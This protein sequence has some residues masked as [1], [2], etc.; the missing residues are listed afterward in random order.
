MPDIN[1]QCFKR[2]LSTPYIYAEFKLETAIYWH[3]GKMSC[4]SRPT[5]HWAVCINFNI[6]SPFFF[7][8]CEASP[9]VK[10]NIYG[11]KHHGTAVYK[12]FF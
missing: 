12:L 6:S 4:D 8:N 7:R 2:S 5:R 11:I 9:A 10:P 1:A 3:I